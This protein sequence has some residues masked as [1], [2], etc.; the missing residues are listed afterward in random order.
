MS[1]AFATTAAHQHAVTVF[2]QCF[3][4]ATAPTRP[5]VPCRLCR[6]P[7]EQPAR[8]RGREVHPACSQH[9]DTLTRMRTMLDNP[10]FQAIFAAMKAEDKNELWYE[11]H[12]MS[13]AIPRVQYPKGTVDADGKPLRGFMRKNGSDR[14]CKA[15]AP[16]GRSVKGAPVSLSHLSTIEITS[17]LH[18]SRRRWNAFFQ[19]QKSF[20]DV[21]FGTCRRSIGR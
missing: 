12:A 6:K 10:E 17:L 8:G 20:H 1:N 4:D 15:A 14:Q 2:V 9:N 5:A 3:V 13:T 11:I 21:S 16:V 7:V 19:S 18:S